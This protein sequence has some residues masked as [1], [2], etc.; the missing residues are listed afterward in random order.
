MRKSRGLYP[1]RKAPHVMQKITELKQ[2]IPYLRKKIREWEAYQA[3][4]KKTAPNYTE[5]AVHRLK[6][7]LAKQ[8]TLLKTLEEKIA[9]KEN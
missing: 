8:L 2:S 5:R 4:I 7:K 1:D 9:L 3:E 6:D